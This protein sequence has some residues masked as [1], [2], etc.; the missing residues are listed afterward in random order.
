[1]LGLFSNPSSPRRRKKLKAA[2]DRYQL[3]PGENESLAVAR[4]LLATGRLDVAFRWMRKARTHFPG[5]P[6]IEKLYNQVK[7]L[8]TQDAL[9]TAT[10]EAKVKP[11]P[12][13]LVRMCE[14]LRMSGNWK[15]AYMSTLEAQ[16]QIPDNWEIYLVLARLFFQRFSNSKNKKYGR[17]TLAQLNQALELNPGEYRTL[18]LLAMTH[19]R[20]EQFEEAGA[21]LRDLLR[22]A[23]RD[24]KATNL[25]AF[26]KK[27]APHVVGSADSG[28]ATTST[29]VVDG[30]LLEKVMTIPGAVGAFQFDANGEVVGTLSRECQSFD[31]SA[32]VEVVESMAGA[33]H[34]DTR[35]LGLGELTCCTLR[36]EG[37][38]MGYRPTGDGGVLVFVEDN[39][40]EEQIAVD[41][42]SA[43][44]QSYAMA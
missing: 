36:G 11:S 17:L 24:A 7:K 25:L 28:T 13:N 27:T 38:I 3:N 43:L 15:N 26:L 23:P 44:G 39:V 32:P 9:R 40:S 10:Q 42:E 20:L 19:V 29:G 35:R 1:M 12:Q 2:Y 33:C 14:L 30:N 8:K 5:S 41:M 4:N 18:L 16:R 21:V 37:W 31:S 6:K 22:I 34:L